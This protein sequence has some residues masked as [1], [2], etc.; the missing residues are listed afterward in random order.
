M[1]PIQLA[2]SHFSVIAWKCFPFQELREELA[3]GIIISR[4]RSCSP[5]LSD[6]E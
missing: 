2:S 4:A 3:W 6:V 5:S 1:N